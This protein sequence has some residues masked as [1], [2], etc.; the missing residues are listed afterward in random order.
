MPHAIT[1]AITSHHMQ[2]PVAN[3]CA[4]L[5]ACIKTEMVRACYAE[6]SPPAKHGKSASGQSRPKEKDAF[7][8]TKAERKTQVQKAAETAREDAAQAAMAELQAHKQRAAQVSII[9]PLTYHET[10]VHAAGQIAMASQVQDG[11]I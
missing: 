2:S 6:P 5:H 3:P 10:L 11:N 4:C 7:F 8:M 9:E 1:E